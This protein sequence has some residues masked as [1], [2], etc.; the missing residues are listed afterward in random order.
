MLD[1]RPFLG[2]RRL[3]GLGAG[4]LARVPLPQEP[5]RELLHP[6]VALPPDRVHAQEA[7]RAWSKVIATSAT[8]ITPAR[9]LSP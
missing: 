6:L 1:E 5:L 8:A 2:R 7:D 9:I 4:R 3:F